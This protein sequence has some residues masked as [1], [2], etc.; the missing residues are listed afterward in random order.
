MIEVIHR[1]AKHITVYP[2]ATALIIDRSLQNTC[3]RS[4]VVIFESDELMWYILP[5]GHRISSQDQYKTTLP[6]PLYMSMQ[7][8]V[9]DL[10]ESRSYHSEILTQSLSAC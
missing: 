4:I 3:T 7:R 1:D 6:H 8:S 9:H 5:S 2:F 10:E